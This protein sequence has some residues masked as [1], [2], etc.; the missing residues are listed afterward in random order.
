MPF[1]TVFTATYNRAYILSQLFRS[2]CAQTCKDFEWLIIDDGSEDETSKLVNLWASQNNGFPIR[3][4]KKENGGKPRAINYGVGRA[5]GKFFFMV[6]SDDILIP[7]AVSKLKKWCEEI[8]EDEDII[9]VGAARGYPDGTYL[10]GIAPVANSDGY[11]DATNLERIQYN[12]DAD[13]CEAYKTEIFKRFPMAEWPGEQFAPE[14]IALNE[15]ALAGYKIRWHS[16]IIYICDYLEDG[17]TKGS[18]KLEAKNP[19]GYAMMYNHMLKY[20]FYSKREKI[21]A[22]CQYVALSFT[23]KHPEYILKTNNWFYTI[24]ALPIGWILSFRRKNQY[25]EI[26]DDQ[27]HS[28]NL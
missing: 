23:G 12:L 20:P 21:F 22:A 11:V 8:Q 25:R 4:Y 7:D 19:M 27:Y 1:I 9:G 2:L 13:M 17:L 15:I 26:L 6:D 28:S 3:Y 16:D 14:Q 24:I 18:R 10:K 5:N